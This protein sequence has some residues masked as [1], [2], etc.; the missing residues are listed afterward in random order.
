VSFINTAFGRFVA[1]SIA[2]HSLAL[3]LF[4]IKTIP[5]AALPHPIT[6]S[7]LPPQIERPSAPVTRAPRAAPAPRV[8]KAP[9]IVAKKDL[10]P[11]EVKQ[12]PAP[13]REPIEPAPP[14]RA[15]PPK[16][17]ILPENTVVVERPLPSLK[18]LL[19][20]VTYS[21]SGE[22]STGPVNLNTRDPLYVSYFTRIKQNIEQQWQYP[23]AALRYGL[24]GRLALEFTIG[25]GGQLEHLRMIRSSGSQ[26]LDDEAMRA[27]RAAAPFPPIP[28]WIKPVPLPISATMEYDDNRINTR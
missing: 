26:V 21:S 1:L 15:E 25:G 23:E 27:V 2:L 6:V 11:K 28:S 3:F 13:L 8:S 19:P 12:R 7:L 22:R 5:Q 24:Q 16:R 10:A 14:P 9:A 17:E 18:D 4:S 20:S